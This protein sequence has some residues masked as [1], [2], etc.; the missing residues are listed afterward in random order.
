M[1]FVADFFCHPHVWCN[2]VA[3]VCL[4]T[5][6]CLHGSDTDV[7]D[8]LSAFLVPTFVVQRCEWRLFADRLVLAWERHRRQCFFIRFGRC[9]HWWCNDVD[10]VFVADLLVLA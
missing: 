7:N 2:D 5:F 4:R 9:P 1:I 10:G 3:G 6:W 8:L